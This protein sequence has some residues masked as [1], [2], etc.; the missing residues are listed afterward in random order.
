MSEL[1]SFIIQLGLT[2]KSVPMNEGMPS[3]DSEFQKSCNALATM[4]QIMIDLLKTGQ[5]KIE[6]LEKINNSKQMIGIL[7]KYVL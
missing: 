1:K 6:I 2:E 3:T 7:K 4:D 5:E